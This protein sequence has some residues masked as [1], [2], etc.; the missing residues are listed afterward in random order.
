LPAAS[1]EVDRKSDDI[2]VALKSAI[3]QADKRGE[4]RDIKANFRGESNK[5]RASLAYSFCV[6][7]LGKIAKLLV[8]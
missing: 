4:K 3:A 5:I 6:F 2:I 1:T 8:M 7:K